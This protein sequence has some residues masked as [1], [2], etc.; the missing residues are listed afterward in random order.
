MNN[1][2]ARKPVVNDTIL[3]V[4]ERLYDPE[5]VTGLG[6]QDLEPGN[7]YGMVI[8]IGV[9]GT[10]IL[11]A[12]FL[13]G[14]ARL[15]WGTGGGVIGAKEGLPEAIAQ[16]AQSLV[17]AAI[18]LAP[19]I[20]V[21]TERTLPEEGQVRFAFLCKGEVRAIMG[22]I[23][24]LQTNQTPLA[25]LWYAANVLMNLLLRQLPENRR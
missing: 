24:Q 14:T 12:G 2:E 16:T 15:Y 13:E 3:G 18:P 17:Y 20:P 23:A 9:S 4:R 8:E 22:G 6:L 5:L 7:L 19:S 21:E 10:V 1:N 11:V 25:I